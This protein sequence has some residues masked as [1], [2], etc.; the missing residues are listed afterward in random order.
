MCSKI[1]F[2]GTC[3]LVH[4]QEGGEWKTTFQTCYNHFKYIVIPFGCT[5]PRVIFQHV[6]NDVFR[7][8]LGDFLV[9]YINDI[10]IFLKNMEEH[11]Y[12]VCLVLE[13]IQEIKLH[14]K[15]VKCEFH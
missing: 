6:I 9:Y 2:H 8:Y 1:D 10:P 13:K 14:A 5:N 11:E 12:H 15:L 4:I 3:N 7:E